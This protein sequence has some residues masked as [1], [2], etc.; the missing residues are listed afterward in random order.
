MKK[1]SF[2]QP[3]VR[4]PKKFRSQF[5]ASWLIANYKPCRVL[6]VG[7]GK[8]L[9]SYLLNGA[10]WRSCVC[11]PFYQELPNKYTDLNKNKIAIPKE[12]KV[13]RI[14][15]KF[16]NDLVADFDLII[17]LHAHGANMQIIDSCAEFKK[18]FM[19]LPC[20][21]ID[22][23]IEKREG[24]DWRLSLVDYAREK[25]FIVKEEQF[26]FKGKNV[27]LYTDANLVRRTDIDNELIKFL[28][29]ADAKRIIS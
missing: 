2:K 20:C 23:P 26:N 11:D 4:K 8:G 13:P 17:G 22:E 16:T 15:Q 3:K 24:V 1:K 6:D 18:D 12:A 27:A 7:G 25:G 10:G 19:L 5:I 21:V 29:I 28:L 9:L 14:T